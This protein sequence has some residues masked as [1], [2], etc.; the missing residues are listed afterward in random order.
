MNSPTDVCRWLRIAA[1]T[2]MVVVVGPG[3]ADAK[4]CGDDVDGQDVPCACGD[5]VASNVTLGDDPVTS[6]TCP[7]DGLI[8]RAMGATSSLT[9][10]LNGHTL[11]GAGLG[12]GIWAVQG[13]PGGA[14]IVSTGGPG[15]IEGFQDGVMAHGG[16]SLALLDGLVL[17]SNRRDGL[18][19]FDVTGAEVRNVEAVESGRD[20]FGIMGKSI[21]LASTRA[22]AN[23]RNGYHIMGWGNTIGMPGAG[24][25]AD[26]NGQAG[27]EL[28][29]EEHQ[30]VECVATGSGNHGLSGTGEHHMVMGCLAQGNGGDGL[31]GAGEGWRLA[32]NQAL[33]ND[34][35]GI[36]IEGEEMIDEGGNVGSGNQ[37]L[38]QSRP[39]VQCEIG[40]SP[41][42]P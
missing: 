1:V 7:S 26:A 12:A 33:D 15:T 5:V 28:M 41:C 42:Q 40:R 18:R 24:L 3:P 2:L 39:V 34:S 6:T 10:D 36:A 35:N 37:G 32:D 17:R 31:H 25:V 11:R 19:M 21:R 16:A 20:G 27:F 23:R 22:V 4:R 29:G 14:R 9:I 38:G 30:V 8:V 13:G